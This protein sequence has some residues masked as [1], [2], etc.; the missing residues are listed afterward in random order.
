MGEDHLPLESLDLNYCRVN[1]MRSPSPSSST[2][3]LL[4]RH[5]TRKAHVS[6]S[7]YL[8]MSV[9]PEYVYVP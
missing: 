4:S 7:L 6:P 8:R 1:V 9:D 2:M 3:L 5:V